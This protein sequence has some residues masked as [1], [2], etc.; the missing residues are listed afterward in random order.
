MLKLAEKPPSVTT[1]PFP[2]P[3]VNMVN[4]NWLEQ[5][6]GKLT[7][8]ASPN[9]DRRVTREA[10]YRPKATIFAGSSQRGKYQLTHPKK[11]KTES[12][13]K[14]SI[15][16]ASP[17]V[18]Q[19]EPSQSQDQSGPIPVEGQEDWTKEY[20]EEQLDYEPSANDQTRLLKTSEQED[21]IE[22]YGEEQMEYDGELDEETK[23]FSA[24]CQSRQNCHEIC[25][26]I[27]LLLRTYQ[28][29]SQSSQTF[30]HNSKLWGCSYSQSNGRWRCSH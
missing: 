27:A 19:L 28:R 20:E 29:N 13:S 7:A 14:P 26:R 3:P 21:W 18:N 22:E 17:S 4:L 5:K 1:D 25:R 9:I 16:P 2:Q 6:K 10:N 11:L 8:E 24:E 15:H 23:A 12:P 30:V